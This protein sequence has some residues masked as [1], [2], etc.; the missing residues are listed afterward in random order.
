MGG[1][2]GMD[3]VA[4]DASDAAALV[5]E[6]FVMGPEYRR[7]TSAS[8]SA[9]TLETKVVI[10]AVLLAVVERR[11]LPSLV[12]EQGR[13]KKTNKQTCKLLSNARRFNVHEQA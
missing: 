7:R 12:V 10:L 1:G 11:L 9:R 5:G 3:D 2:E 6:A 4:G 8:A 13:G